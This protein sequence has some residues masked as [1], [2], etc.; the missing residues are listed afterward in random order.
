MSIGTGTTNYTPLPTIEDLKRVA[1]EIKEIQDLT[2][3]QWTLISPAGRVWRGDD[4]LTLAAQAMP[5]SDFFLNSI[6]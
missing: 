1:K 6:S 3:G 5:V 4:P 2:G